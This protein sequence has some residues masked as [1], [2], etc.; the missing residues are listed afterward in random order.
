MASARFNI[1]TAG[2]VDFNKIKIDGIK[3]NKYGGRSAR[4]NY[5]G[6]RFLIQTPRLRLPFGLGVYEEKDDDGRVV[7][8]K[9][10]LDY[11]FAGFRADERNAEKPLVK[12]FFEFVEK[13]ED[14]VKQEAKK[15]S[16][17]W[18]GEPDA[19]DPTIRALFRP[20]IK[21]ARDKSTGK[22]NEAYAPTMKANV[23]Y[24]D[25]RFTLDVFDQHQNKLDDPRGSLVKGSEA[26]SII[27][28]DSV[29]FAGGKFGVKFN[30][31]SVKSFLPDTLR[32]Q[33]AFNDEEDD[34][35]DP[36]ASAA[37]ASAPSKPA[38]STFIEDEDDDE[39]VGEDADEDDGAADE[40]LEAE[41]EDELD[42]DD[43]EEAEAE[44][45][46]EPEPE[47][48]PKPEPKKAAKKTTK[49]AAAKTPAKRG[50]AKKS[51]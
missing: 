31:Q 41:L 21:Y 10:S 11:S 4:I 26:L 29:T 40:D 47:P 17:K 30:V 15:N 3:T 8:T 48:E 32:G 2:T 44:E 7:K 28:I 42:D 39:D 9:Y 14:F 5:D 6:G 25:G 23:G 24:W 49:K 43:E 33:Y 20:I 37:A 45:E 38:P 22:I 18:I 51:G 13:L 19:A 1:Q 50:R 46:S 35:Y 16:F 34:E 36:N 27:S 12:R